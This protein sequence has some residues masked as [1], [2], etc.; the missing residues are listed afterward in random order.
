MVVVSLIQAYCLLIGF[1]GI[2]GIPVEVILIIVSILLLYGIVYFLHHII[3]IF[4]R[5]IKKGVKK[6]Y[7][8]IKNCFRR[9]N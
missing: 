9:K 2:F 4:Y 1:F 3:P 6:A 5:K 7:N 8:K